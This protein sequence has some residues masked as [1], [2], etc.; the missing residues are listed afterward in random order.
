MLA[1]LAGECERARRPQRRIADGAS[2]LKGARRG[3]RAAPAHHA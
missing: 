3:E 1:G 2:P